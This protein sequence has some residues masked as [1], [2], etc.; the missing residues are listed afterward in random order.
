METMFVFH[1]KPVKH[2]PSWI[3]LSGG[4][5]GAG[6][7]CAG[8]G[9]EVVGFTALLS[10]IYLKV[11]PCKTVS[12]SLRKIVVIFGSCLPGR[13]LGEKQR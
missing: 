4:L 8:D 1:P 3:L 12:C 11:A 5:S 9:G 7:G 13:G 6:R 10:Q 2:S